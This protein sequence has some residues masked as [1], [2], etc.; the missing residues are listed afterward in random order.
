MK[1]TDKIK[2]AYSSIPASIKTTLKALPV[3]A[4]LTFSQP[5]EAQTP[6]KIQAQQTKSKEVLVYWDA[7]KDRAYLG[8][9]IPVIAPGDTLRIEPGLVG[10]KGPYNIGSNE[11]LPEGYRF[12]NINGTKSLII[13]PDAKYANLNFWISGAD[14]TE[15]TRVI[16]APDASV[17]N[18]QFKAFKEE[19][20]IYQDRIVAAEQLKELHKDR[21]HEFESIIKEYQQEIN[22]RQRMLDQA[23]EHIAKQSETIREQYTELQRWNTGFMA[24]ARI[25]PGLEKYMRPEVGVFATIG[26]VGIGGIYGLPADGKAQEKFEVTKQEVP[27]N[28]GR[29]QNRLGKDVRETTTTRTSNNYTIDAL[30]SL[31]FSDRASFFLTGGVDRTYDK[32]T[33]QDYMFRQ[34]EDVDGNEVRINETLPEPKVNTSATNYGR[35][36]GGLLFRVN[37]YGSLMLRG[38]VTPGKANTNQSWYDAAVGVQLN[39]R[40]AFKRK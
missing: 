8:T 3:A 20:R 2:E 37:D 21:A 38:S 24:G 11:K 23:F 39:L 25:E 15:S 16:L 4:A 26:R 14:S 7:E 31:N 27:N 22:S 40:N 9:G 35:F 36:G 28:T 1:L 30:V 13:S 19:I 12:E 34:M 10:I 29:P 17:V 33:I 32:E 18:K 5:T 6:K